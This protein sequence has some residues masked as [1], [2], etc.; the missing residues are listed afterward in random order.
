MLNTTAELK[1]HTK[2]DLAAMAKRL[3]VA[4]TG[5]MRKD[6]L[7]S[8]VAKASK[9]SA[10]GKVTK[11][12]AKAG[13]KSKASKSP[14]SPIAKTRSATKQSAASKSV[15][16]HAEVGKTAKAEAAGARRSKTNGKSSGPQAAGRTTSSNSKRNPGSKVASKAI[17]AAKPSASSGGRKG[18]SA[19]EVVAA[20]KRAVSDKKK[21]VVSKS[22]TNPNVLK[23]IRELQNQKES[24]KD[25]S[26]RPTLVRPPGA[27][28]PIW[29]KEPQS[30]RI[31]LFV[32][33][34]YWLHAAWDITRNAIDRAKAAMAEQWHGAKPVLR[35]L[36][37]DDGS[38]TSSSE[39]VERDIEIHGGLR[40][41]YIDWSGESVR[42][43]V[44]VGYLAPN[45]RYHAIAKSNI[46][47]T[48][49][50]GT[51]EAVD[52]NWS[53]AS[54]ESERIYALS[55][56]YDGEQETS[57]LKQV[58]EDRTHRNL[59]A[60][61]LA[62]IGVAAESPFRRRGGFHF[63]MEVELVVYGSTVPDGYL[64]LSGEPVSLR[65]DGSFAVRL[66]FPDRRQVLPAVA[67]ARDGS[68]QRTIVV[69]VERNTKVMEP[70]EK[71]RDTGE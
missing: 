14:K 55:G 56:G 57:E 40:N 25:I 29:E 23:R 58:L 39:T 59:G 51:P 70:L 46:V 60:P 27:S 42:F 18:R 30:D 11:A 50:A 9:A 64:T 43:R 22:K 4:V 20:P 5:S 65:S 62:K 48:P 63:D 37:L 54:A 3:G 19:D 7:V 53:D 2:A 61:A 16:A 10:R 17:A 71:E 38:T 44:L 12:R 67:C 69:A 33:D 24:S 28:E 21:A 1:A 52:E 6:E 32:R 34:A 13:T 47:R 15:A 8:V 31:A 66:P 68:Q 45:G 49:A 35:L 36:R 26:F 41:W